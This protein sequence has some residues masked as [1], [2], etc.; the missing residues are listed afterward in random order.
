ML[1]KLLLCASP[2]KVGDLPVQAQQSRAWD[3]WEGYISCQYPYTPLMRF[4]GIL[5]GD[6][7]AH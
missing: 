4:A 2:A 3:K 7:L 1:T 5:Q 6:E